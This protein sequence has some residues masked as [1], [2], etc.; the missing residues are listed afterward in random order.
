[1]YLS[2][3]PDM[4]IDDDFLA[5]M[6]EQPIPR[7]AVAISTQDSHVLEID[8]AKAWDELGLKSR[9]SN[10]AGIKVYFNI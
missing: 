6:Q 2:S 7:S 5:T 1:M 3:L 8:I 4:K 10:E 9:W